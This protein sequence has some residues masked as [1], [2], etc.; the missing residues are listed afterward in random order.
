LKYSDN[1]P[2]NPIKSMREFF[3]KYHDTKWDEIEALKEEIIILNQENPK[4]M[5]KVLLLEE[6][7]EYEKRQY[8]LKNIYKAFEIE[9]G[10]IFIFIYF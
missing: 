2:K 9:K 8:R 3:G 10:V 1:R 5:E 7:L 4:L 6:E